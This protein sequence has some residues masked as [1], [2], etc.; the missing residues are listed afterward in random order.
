ML[1]FF[2]CLIILLATFVI[3]LAITTIQLEVRDFRLE[4][5]KR[6]DGEI[7]IVLKIFNLVPYLKI[8]I[9]K[10]KLIKKVNIKN[11][12]KSIANTKIKLLKKDI[13]KIL[14]KTRI[15]RLYI[16]I[17][18]Q[19]ENIMLMTFLATIISTMLSI[20]YTK[21]M[22]KKENGKY[23]VSIEYNNPPKYEI[24]I[25]GK[26]KIKP[27]HIIIAICE[28]LKRRKDDKHERKSYRRTYGY[29][30]E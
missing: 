1:V 17:N 4:N 21:N 29:N 18:L 15:E 20:V 8:N 26:L 14:E 7:K 11:V 12:E 9:L 28:I 22:I 19:S 3:L 27:I 2:L 13:E 10:N 23:R 25:D 6:K 16:N 5:N 30:N 24:Y